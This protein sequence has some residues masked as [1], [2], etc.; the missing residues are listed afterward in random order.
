M[1]NYSGANVTLEY[2]GIAN[3]HVIRESFKRLGKVCRDSRKSKWS[4]ITNTHWLDHIS[5]I[6]TAACRIVTYVDTDGCSVLTHCTDGWDRTSQLCAL[7]ELL[8]DPYYRT[9]KGFIVL[10]CKEFI[11]FGHKF[12]TRNGY[13]I[14]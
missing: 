6:L 11:S 5:S 13:G 9:I 10:I 7:A 4:D 1:G 8:M 12:N 3:I 2:C 14:N